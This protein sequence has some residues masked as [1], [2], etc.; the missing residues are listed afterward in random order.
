MPRGAVGSERSV[1]VR[2]DRIGGAAQDASSTLLPSSTSSVSPSSDAR[3]SR[4]MDP[5]ARYAARRW[6]LTVELC[7]WLAEDL[8]GEG[9]SRID[10]RR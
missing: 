1:V 6:P 7:A 8:A 2:S 10:C 9:A 5:S 3:S 4:A